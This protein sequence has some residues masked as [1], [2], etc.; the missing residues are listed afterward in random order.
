MSP[1]GKTGR[2]LVGDLATDTGKP[3]DGGKTWAFTLRDGVKWEDGS[4]V[5]CA[6]VKY[7]VSRTFAQTVITDGPTYA[8]AVLDIPK[9]KDGNSVYKGPYETSKNDTGGLRQGRGVLVD[10]K[11]ITF[12]LAKPVR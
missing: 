8:I 3:T 4:D 12:H 2:Q 1:D 9:D 5:T 11:T 6:D 7:G 10:G